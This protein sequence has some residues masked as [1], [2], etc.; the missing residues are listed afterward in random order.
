MPKAKSQEIKKVIGAR[1]LDQAYEMVAVS[2]LKPHPKNARK[3]DNAAIDQSIAANGF[4]GAV[5]VQRSTG[6]I[7]AGKH[8]WERAA[9]AAITEIPVLWLDVDDKAA[10]KILAADNRVLD[11]AEYDQEAL[12]TLLNTIASDCGTLDGSGYVIE[13]LDKII[14]DLGSQIM[15]D[16]K[17]KI[18][19]LAPALNAPVEEAYAE[20][21]LVL[22]RCKDEAEQLAL[23]ERFAAEG[24]E[25]SAMSR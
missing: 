3:S 23:L 14:S 15:R 8:R 12:V 21:W 17:E 24:L 6:F 1:V 22:V 16:A 13:D 2:E 10:L 25:C 19:Q 5:C 18:A 20:Q 7:L 4:Y 11:N 9:A